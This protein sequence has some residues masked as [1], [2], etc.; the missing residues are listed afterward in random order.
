MTSQAK[1]V[2]V[3]SDSAMLLAEIRKS[4]HLLAV[5]ATKD[6]QQNKAIAFLDSAGF[7]PRDIAATLG[8]TRNAVSIALHRMRKSADAGSA[9]MADTTPTVDGSQ[10]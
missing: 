6:M 1:S 9:T 4:N 5:M 2:G 3:P 8:V 10:I 7:E